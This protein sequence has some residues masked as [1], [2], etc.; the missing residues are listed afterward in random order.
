MRKKLP[1]AV[2]QKRA[3]DRNTTE[4]MVERP[5]QLAQLNLKL[6]TGNIAI[7]EGI[8][9]SGKTSIGNY[10]RFTT[11]N[12]LTPEIEISCKPNIGVEMFIHNILAAI[13]HEIHYKKPNKDGHEVYSD[14]H[15]ISQSDIAQKLFKRYEPYYESG[16][17]LSFA[18]FGVG[19]N[20]TYKENPSLSK[21]QLISDMKELG[22]VIAKSQ[23]GH[24]SRILIQL[25]NF[26][27]SD[28]T[29]E[30]SEGDKL[31]KFFSSIRDI[32]IL[33]NYSWIINGTEGIGRRLKSSDDGASDIMPEALIVPSV[34]LDEC[35]EIID[36]RVKTYTN[37]QI[38]NFPITDDLL[39]QVYEIC[40]P[41]LRELLATLSLLDQLS[42]ESE[43]INLDTASKT[44][45]KTYPIYAELTTNR[46]K[47]MKA[48]FSNPGS[49]QTEIKKITELGQSTI[50]ENLSYLEENSL[51]RVRRVE[52]HKHYKLTTN[53]FLATHHIIK[54]KL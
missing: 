16:G 54:E 27:I 14:F 43:S 36:L 9:G 48:I 47:L 22:G 12:V 31:E 6:E 25:E 38:K 21:V 30:Y 45:F 4:L 52:K 37:N 49:N 40:K 15:N 34:T 26:D 28:K 20:K 44:L 24:E 53:S 50:S 32:L 8:K 2:Y 51:I 10:Y 19:G 23:T 11:E 33:E 42:L 29:S 41:S 5:I 7:L 18:G 13:T 39:K 1:R 17:S 46:K 35:R 3:I